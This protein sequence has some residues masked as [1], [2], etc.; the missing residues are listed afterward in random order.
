MTPQPIQHPVDAVRF[1]TRWQ[2]GS[3]D[4]DDRQP[5]FAGCKDLCDSP[6]SARVF[7]NDQVNVMIAH[8]L[9]IIDERKRAAS[10]N[11]CGVRQWKR[12]RRRIDQSQKVMMLRGGCKRFQMHASHRQKHALRWLIQCRDSASD[13]RDRD[14]R[15]VL[16]LCPR[17]AG[18]GDKRQIGGGTRCHRVAAHLTSERMRGVDHMG[19]RVVAKVALQTINAAKA[20]DANRQRLLFWLRNTSGQRHHRLQAQVRQTLAQYGGFKR[21]AEDQKVWC[22]G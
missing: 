5:K 7:G 22:N 11:G 21:P 3:V 4:H 16:R 10:D 6:G 12:T 18:Q 13:V 1:A 8:Q 9:E 2:H 19:D 20:A 17:H 14:P 15:V